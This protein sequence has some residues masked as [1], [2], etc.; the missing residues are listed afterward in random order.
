MNLTDRFQDL[1]KGG[2]KENDPNDPNSG[3]VV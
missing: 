1:I 3:A 2:R